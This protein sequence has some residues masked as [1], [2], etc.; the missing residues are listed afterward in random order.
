MYGCRANAHAIGD[1]LLE[2]DFFLQQP[3]S[4]DHAMTYFNP[5]CLVP[6]GCDVVPMWENLDLKDGA[7][8]ANLTAATKSQVAELLDSA[9]GP[10]VFRKAQV[11]EILKTPLRE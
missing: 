1:M 2:Y 5:H 9:C 4:F 6:D 11:S 3:D 10:T 7:R 8:A